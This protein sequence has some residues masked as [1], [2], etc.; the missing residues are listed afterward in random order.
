MTDL[1]GHIE[2]VLN[3]DVSRD[4]KYIASASKDGTVK[5]WSSKSYKLLQN[6]VIP[7]SI[8]D[9]INQLSFSPDSKKS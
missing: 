7:N 8:I 9:I 6:L 3:L 4:G 5:I 1:G 2:Q